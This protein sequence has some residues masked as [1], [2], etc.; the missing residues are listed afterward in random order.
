[1][2]STPAPT[3][4]PS[5]FDG[6]VDPGLEQ[7]AEAVVRDAH[8]QRAPD[9]GGGMDNISTEAAAHALL[10]LIADQPGQMG[11][12]R[13]ARIIGGYAVPHRDEEEAARLTR[14]SIQLDWPLREI[15]RLVDALINGSL[16]AQTA[17]PRPVLVLTR[18]GFAALGVLEGG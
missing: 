10:R 2:H 7:Q 14:Y 6:P 4:I 17:G 8:A 13:A 11:R 16:L 5:S 12:L 18:S 15:V 9:S 1:M 3:L